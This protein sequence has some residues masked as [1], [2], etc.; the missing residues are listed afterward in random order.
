MPLKSLQ[1]DFSNKNYAIWKKIH[2]FFLLLR[3]L[4][5]KLN[6]L[7]NSGYSISEIWSCSIPLSLISNATGLTWFGYF[8]TKLCRISHNDLIMDWFSRA[9]LYSMP[10]VTFSSFSS[11]IDTW[12]TK[13]CLH[14]VTFYRIPIRCLER[15]MMIFPS[16]PLWDEI[17]EPKKNL[18]STD[19]ISENSVNQDL[20]Y[21]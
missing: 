9:K 4:I 6:Y 20:K 8:K 12:E 7:C 21:L 17:R 10:R 15:V 3:C 2:H 16:S 1:P 19:H 13:V 5:L 14:V 18:N 11:E